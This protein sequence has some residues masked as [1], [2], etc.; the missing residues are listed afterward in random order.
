M[1]AEDVL[2]VEDS[3]AQPFYPFSFVFR[4]MVW[5]SANDAPVRVV[6]LVSK[7]DVMIMRLWIRK[8]HRF[9]GTTADGEMKSRLADKP[10]CKGK[11]GRTSGQDGSRGLLDG[12]W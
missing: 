10:A 9:S 2:G 3:E 5:K 8:F 12:S 11:K 7:L 6:V 1:A 4:E